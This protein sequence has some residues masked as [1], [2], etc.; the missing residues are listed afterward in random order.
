MSQKE[1]VKKFWLLLLGIYL[2][3]VAIGGLLTSFPA[4][5]GKMFVPILLGAGLLKWASSQKSVR[6]IYIVI[7]GIIVVF[8]FQDY[9]E[10]RQ[11][12]LSEISYGCEHNNA[13]VN[14]TTTST[15]QKL[16][17]C[18][19]MAHELV[20]F[21]VLRSIESRFSR[22]DSDVTAE[23]ISSD[24]GMQSKMASSQVICSSKISG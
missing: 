6:N 3:S 15:Q 4:A 24:I 8:L 5:I 20:D 7:I 18:G 21:L 2:L 9:N 13:E 16:D 12:A 17:Y 10:V 22:S 23:T 1:K 11:E 14:A 19:C